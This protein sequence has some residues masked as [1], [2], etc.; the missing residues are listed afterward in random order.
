MTSNESL[1]RNDIAVDQAGRTVYFMNR[2][3]YYYEDIAQIVLTKSK[4]WPLRPVAQQ[5]VSSLQKFYRS[6]AIRLVQLS[7][8]EDYEQYLYQWE[9][10]LWRL[11]S[12]LTKDLFDHVEFPKPRFVDGIKFIKPYI[13]EGSHG[14]VPAVTINTEQVPKAKVVRFAP[15]KRFELPKFATL[16]EMP[17]C[18]RQ[19]Q[20][21][22]FSDRGS[23]Q[24]EVPVEI[25]D[26]IQDVQWRGAN[27]DMQRTIH[28]QPWSD[29]CGIRCANYPECREP[30]QSCPS[31]L[32]R[33]RSYRMYSR[34]ADPQ[35]R[36][37]SPPRHQMEQD[38]P[39]PSTS[40][41]H[42]Y[43]AGIGASEASGSAQER[44]TNLTGPEDLLKV[45]VEGFSAAMMMKPI[46]RRPITWKHFERLGRRCTKNSIPEDSV[47]ETYRPPALPR[48]PVAAPRPLDELDEIQM[49]LGLPAHQCLSLTSLDFLTLDSSA[50]DGII[51]PSYGESN[52]TIVI[53]PK[54]TLRDVRMMVQDPDGLKNVKVWMFGQEEN[55][56]ELQKSMDKHKFFENIR[57]WGYYVL[58]VFPAAA[59]DFAELGIPPSSRFSNP[60]VFAMADPYRNAVVVPTLADC[61]ANH[62]RAERHYSRRVP[63]DCTDSLV[64]GAD[65]PQFLHN[66]I[67]DNPQ[68]LAVTLEMD[69]PASRG[70]GGVRTRLNMLGVQV[71]HFVDLINAVPLLFPQWHIKDVLYIDRSLAMLCKGGQIP[72]FDDDPREPK[73]PLYGNRFRKGERQFR[74]L[75]VNSIEMTMLD[76]SRAVLNC[77][78]EVASAENVRLPGTPIFPYVRELLLY[79]RDMPSLFWLAERMEDP[80]WAIRPF[81]GWKNDE[82]VVPSDS[83]TGN[84]PPWFGGQFQSRGIFS[85]AKETP[86]KVAKNKS[87][88]PPFCLYRKIQSFVHLLNTDPYAWEF[89]ESLVP[90][91]LQGDDSFF[92]SGRN[93]KTFRKIAKETLT[94]DLASCCV[95]DQCGSDIHFTPG[96]DVPPKDLQCIYP[97]CTVKKPHK[98]K[99]CP[100]VIRQCQACGR[101]GH[102]SYHHQQYSPVQLNAI[103][104]Q[105][106]AFHLK[107][108]LTFHTRADPII[109]FRGEV[110]N[111]R[112]PWYS[113]YAGAPHH[114]STVLHT[115]DII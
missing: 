79:L 60:E 28:I 25:D 38:E 47:V 86:W 78:M 110:H 4:V 97:L 31:K 88:Q 50:R 44:K 26:R 22:M 3:Y 93:V 108:A 69:Y 36:S 30:L 57:K 68:I 27:V 80:E 10:S 114:G 54:D 56:K 70:G 95:C 106:S 41:E 72:A 21:D 65:V 82:A 12:V 33:E 45:Y 58:F 46:A 112:Q 42:I 35:D 17:H 81:R 6:E 29:K 105:Y 5:S 59:R 15:L 16:S 77:A 62:N 40:S 11:F 90:L 109:S 96:C 107:A 48:E 49:E 113:S 1:P 51:V 2:R 104:R 32:N 20:V 34:Q 53:G 9:F 92:P 37:R 103:M 13:A 87:L 73:N 19:H 55:Y 76:I 24:F 67:A 101:L 52:R 61:G 83:T 99:V 85:D 71:P 14:G 39:T 7:E 111:V 63:C 89:D 100:F 84:I 102:S 23:Y 91:K 43:C 98:I 74:A 75:S 94:F 115:K 8:N 66:F 18:M 64:H